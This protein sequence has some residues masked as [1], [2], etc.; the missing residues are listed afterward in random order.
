MGILPLMGGAIANAGKLTMINCDFINNTLSSSRNGGGIYN[1]G[2]YLIINSSR[3]ENNQASAGGALCL[4]GNHSQIIN[5]NLTNNSALGGAI[6]IGWPSIYGNN[7]TINNSNFINN[8]GSATAG[9]IY[10]GYGSNVS[11]YNSR[12]INGTGVTSAGTIYNTPTG[13]M[14]L[15]NCIFMNNSAVYSGGA[16]FSSENLTIENFEFFENYLSTWASTF[17][18]GA[19]FIS[20]TGTKRV[21]IKNTNFRNNRAYFGGAIFANGNISVNITNFGFRIILFMM[22]E[23][24][25][26]EIVS[27]CISN[28]TFRNN[29]TENRGTIY[30]SPGAKMFLSKNLMT[31]N[32]ANLGRDI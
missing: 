10:N 23:Q 11:I 16:I 17:G 20:R 31:E 22:E 24:F 15:S 18:G 2:N 13:S 12:F 6:V 14:L 30:N 1:T 9:A 29:T 7:I 21:I 27:P 25:V 26:L 3:F 19:L 8:S 28:S 5:S 4:N 32:I